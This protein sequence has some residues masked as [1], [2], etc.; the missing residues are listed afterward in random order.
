M[1]HGLLLLMV[2]VELEVW[3]LLLLQRLGADVA[4]TWLLGQGCSERQ[5]RLAATASAR[6][7]SNSDSTGTHQHSR[8]HNKALADA[9]PH[10]QDLKMFA[11]EQEA[12]VTGRLLTNGWLYEGGV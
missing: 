10:H 11:A 12:C 5:G 2:V 9:P 6:P 7:A 8:Q 3:R 1:V 4:T